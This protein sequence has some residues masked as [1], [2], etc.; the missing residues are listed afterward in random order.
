MLYQAAPLTADRPQNF[1][2][3]F[4]ATLAL[5][6]PLAAANLLQMMVHA[7]DVI[8]VARLGT[9]DLAAATLGVFMFNLTMYALIGL[10]SA[11]APLLPAAT[12]QLRA[13]R[14]RPMRLTGLLANRVRKA[15]SSSHRRSPSTRWGMA[16]SGEAKMTKT[17]SPLAASVSGH[18]FFRSAHH[19][20]VSL[21]R[22]AAS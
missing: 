18:S 13:M 20:S 9:V 8:F 21:R 2:A 12:R 1:R 10:T 4:R 5:A 6:V 22:P 3:E 14:S 11:A 17:S 15:G 16:V 19:G 7:I